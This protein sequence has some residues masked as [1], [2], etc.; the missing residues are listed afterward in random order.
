MLLYMA[1]ASFT[2][3]YTYKLTGALFEILWLPF[4]LLLLVLP[5]VSVVYWVK[6]QFN[7]KSL[8][9]YSFLIILVTFLLLFL[10]FRSFRG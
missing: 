3:V 9:F 1:A 4:M 5:V 7:F 2:N 6:E 8:F 10:R